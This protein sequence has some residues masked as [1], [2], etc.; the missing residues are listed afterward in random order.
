MGRGCHYVVKGVRRGKQQTKQNRIT[1][2]QCE[3]EKVHKRIGSS[4]IR[5]ARR[6]SKS[7]R[8]HG[9]CIETWIFQIESII[10]LSPF[11]TQQQQQQQHQG[12]AATPDSGRQI[13]APQT[14]KKDPTRCRPKRRVRI[15]RWCGAHCSSQQCIRRSS[16]TRAAEYYSG[17]PTG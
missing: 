13:Q 1:Y 12:T 2:V 4:T 5:V 3:L 16:C 10:I 14:S 9:T 8:N 11:I 7:N 17:R 6:G 15:R